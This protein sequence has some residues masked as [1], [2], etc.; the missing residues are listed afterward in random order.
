MIDSRT[1]ELCRMLDERGVE[2]E[3]EW[4][5]YGE[6]IIWKTENGNFCFYE[7]GRMGSVSLTI[8]GITPQQAIAATLGSGTLTRC[9]ATTAKGDGKRGAR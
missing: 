8:N 1:T 5:D 4:V 2:W 6:Q 9:A 3:H 7:T